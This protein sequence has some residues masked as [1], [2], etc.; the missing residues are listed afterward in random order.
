M[1]LYDD[2][3]NSSERAFNSSRVA[4]LPKLLDMTGPWENSQHGRRCEK[5]KLLPSTYRSAL[6]ILGS[7]LARGPAAG[8]IAVVDVVTLVRACG[9]VARLLCDLVGQVCVFGGLASNPLRPS[10]PLLKCAITYHR[11]CSLRL[12]GEASCS[13]WC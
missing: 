6:V 2:L 11:W 5:L 1:T 7:S 4:G 8:D 10:L 9:G 13:S 3:F 12:R